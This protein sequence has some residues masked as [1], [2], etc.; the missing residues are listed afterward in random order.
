MTKA[1]KRA[2]RA[3]EARA[4]KEVDYFAMSRI[5][6]YFLAELEQPAYRSWLRVYEGVEKGE[7]K[8]ER[9]GGYGYHNALILIGDFQGEPPSSGPDPQADPADQRWPAKCDHCDHVFG[10][11]AF[12]GT[13]NHYLYRRSDN[14]ELTTID[15]AT[16][17]AMWW[18]PWL[19]DSEHWRGF[20]GRTLVVRLPGRHDWIVDSVASNCT[21]PNDRTHR[22][23]IRTGEPPN[24]TVGKSGGNTCS[25]GAGSILTDKW[26]GFL[27]GGY[28][29]K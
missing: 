21:K 6:C 14:G 29:V 22:C 17:G 12:R 20:D 13:H 19:S 9:N 24:V 26:H 18:A 5:P 15:E 25:A 28:L 4:A 8:C 27:R 1:E 11:K 3:A 16:P 23:W 10:Q 7:Q 2:M